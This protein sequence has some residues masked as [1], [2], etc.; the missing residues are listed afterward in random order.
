MHLQ[1]VEYTVRVINDQTHSGDHLL[2]QLHAG[3]TL[4]LQLLPQLHHLPP[5]LLHLLLLQRV[6]R[7]NPLVLLLGS[8]PFGRRAAE[9][10]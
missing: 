8:P 5:Q 1:I 2:L 7:P 9:L 10:L 3:R 4:L 6:W